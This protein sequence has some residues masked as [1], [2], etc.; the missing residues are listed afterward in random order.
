MSTHLLALGLQ[1]IS[2]V[3]FLRSVWISLLVIDQTHRSSVSVL[4]SSQMEQ[5]YSRLQL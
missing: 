2:S 5:E 3:F 4:T 1:K